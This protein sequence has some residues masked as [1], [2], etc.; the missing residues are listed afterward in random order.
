MSLGASQTPLS[1]F[2]R[3]GAAGAS[4][5]VTEPYAIPYKF[6]SPMMQVHYARGCSLAEAFY[7][8]VYCPYQLLIVGDPLCQPWAERPRVFVGGVQPDDIV[9]G[10]LHLQP[11][12]SLARGTVDHFEIFWDGRRVGRC[13][14]GATFDWDTARQADG[15]HD[16]RVVAVGP[17][18]IECQGRRI[19]A[20]R[21][22]NH[23]RKIAASLK[24]L[25]P[26]RADSPLQIAVDSPGSR[27][28][29]AIHGD[30]VVGR[31]SGEKGDIVIPANALG[32]GPVHLEVFALGKGDASTNVIAQPFDLT[33]LSAAT[34]GVK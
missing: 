22:A 5:T 15:Y 34:R 20:V 7:Q 4:G 9:K 11:S 3:A 14:P 21:L 17:R 29:L 28:A 25:P 27:G 19:F 16:L 6:P 1:V 32:A 26:F 12:A 24:T 18:P 13:E 33:L 2:L 8:S 31:I 30:R 10:T 23:G